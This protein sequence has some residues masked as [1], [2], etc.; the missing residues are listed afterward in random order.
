MKTKNGVIQLTKID[1]AALKTVLEHA[2][3]DH[4]WQ[5]NG[6][7]GDGDQLYAREHRMAEHGF[8]VIRFILEVTK[9]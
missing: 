1:Q 5:E 2:E 6:S 8:A 3:R 7:Y 4:S 9:K